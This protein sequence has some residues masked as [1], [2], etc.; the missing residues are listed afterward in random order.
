MSSQI[1]TP[2]ESVQVKT[3]ISD[4]ALATSTTTTGTAVDCL[5]FTRAMIEINSVTNAGTSNTFTVDES[6]DNSSWTANIF[7]AK[8]QFAVIVPSGATGTQ[9]NTPGHQVMTIDL[10]KRKR[11]L[12]VVS[13]TAGATTG[14]MHATIHLFNP[15]Y[16]SVSQ[17][18]TEVLN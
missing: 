6:A 3:S 16:A 1:H 7:S 4:V 11:Y 10:T 2:S 12:R 14:A 15:F 5:G 17:D 9:L 13:V 18:N 8:N